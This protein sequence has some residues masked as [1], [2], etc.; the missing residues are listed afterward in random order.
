LSLLGRRERVGALVFFC[1]LSP[2][3]SAAAVGGLFVCSIISCLPCLVAAVSDTA[4]THD[5]Y[6]PLPVH[7]MFRSRVGRRCTCGTLRRWR[8]GA[9][10]EDQLKKVH[11]EAVTAVFWTRARRSPSEWYPCPPQAAWLQFDCA[12]WRSRLWRMRASMKFW[13]ADRGHATARGPNLTGR[14]KVPAAIPE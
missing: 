10:C 2:T 6:R 11:G 1:P 9:T 8:S 14:G 13:I 4:D 12:L 7:A 5:W 3:A